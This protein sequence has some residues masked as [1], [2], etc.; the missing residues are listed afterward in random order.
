[1]LRILSAPITGHATLLV[2]SPRHSL[3]VAACQSLLRIYDIAGGLV[4]TDLETAVE[5][6]AFTPSG[7][8]IITGGQDAGLSKWDLRP[9]LKSLGWQADQSPSTSSASVG[10]PTVPSQ[11]LASAQV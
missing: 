7:E 6:V 4:V 11:R 1:M 3:V 9:L 10:C 8:H 2:S 5:A